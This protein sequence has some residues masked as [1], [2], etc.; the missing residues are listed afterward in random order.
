MTNKNWFIFFHIC[1]YIFWFLLQLAIRTQPNYLYKL[2]PFLILHL[3]ALGSQNMDITLHP[4]VEYDNDY[5]MMT[6]QR[7]S[8]CVPSGIN[9]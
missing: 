2:L 5:I 7:K 9:L 6:S 3:R 4:A 8:G 1:Y